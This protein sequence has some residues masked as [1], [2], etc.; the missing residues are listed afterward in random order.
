MTPSRASFCRC[1]PVVDQRLPNGQRCRFQRDNPETL[2][3]DHFD[4]L[5]IALMRATLIHLKI[6]RDVI[7]PKTLE[8][9]KRDVGTATDLL[10]G[11]AHRFVPR[12]A[13]MVQRTASERLIRL[14]MKVKPLSSRPRTL[15]VTSSLQLRAGNAA[16]APARWHAAEGR[17]FAENCRTGGPPRSVKACPQ[18]CWR[19]RPPYVSSVRKPRPDE[20]S[21]RTG[22]GF[23]TT[24]SAR[25]TR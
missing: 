18:P 12:S 15:P 14:R 10:D 20:T 3:S 8:R 24:G 23:V 22:R 13:Y 11:I 4:E 1:P 5:C 21:I 9:D 6:C 17:A 2:I 7:E 19:D 16:T 25:R